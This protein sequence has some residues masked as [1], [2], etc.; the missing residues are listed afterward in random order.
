MKKTVIV[1]FLLAIVAVSACSKAAT[2]QKPTEQTNQNNAAAPDSFGSD[3]SN[4]N[5]D[6][7][8]LSSSQLDGADSGL[9]DIDN[10]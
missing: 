1:L 8:E 3:V 4:A 5:S 7:R 2:T 10:M 6:D 9:N